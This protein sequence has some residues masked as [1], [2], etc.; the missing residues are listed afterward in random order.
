LVC[1]VA[2]RQVD[3]PTETLHTPATLPVVTS[4]APAAGPVVGG[5]EA[6]S[7]CPGVSGAFGNASG[8]AGGGNGL[9]STRP[10]GAGVKG[11]G[12]ES[13]GPTRVPVQPATASAADIATTVKPLLAN[14]I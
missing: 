8:A 9:V 12:P 3:P 13:I 2:R 1:G 10:P 5:S 4:G 6:T 7:C 14:A 11:A